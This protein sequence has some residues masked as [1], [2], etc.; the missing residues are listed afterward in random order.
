MKEKSYPFAF[1]ES[2]YRFDS[3]SVNKKIRKSVFLTR[4]MNANLFNLALM[5][6]TTDGQL[7]DAVESRNGD[8]REILATVYQI[9][10]HFLLRNPEIVVGFYGNDHRRH[11]LY[12]MAI[13]QTLSEISGKFEI[14]GNMDGNIVL[15][16]PDKEYNAYYIKRI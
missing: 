13:A 9:V 16:E 3:V 1:E 5:D 2:T 12:R 15:F 8:V 14:Y 11:R 6:E 10:D 4:S 7:S